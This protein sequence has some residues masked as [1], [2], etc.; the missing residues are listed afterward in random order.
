MHPW[1]TEQ[2]AAYFGAIGGTALGCL[3]GL[4]GTLA[5]IYAPRGRLRRTVLGLMTFSVALG[6]ICLI[7]GVI[8]LI[9]HQPYAVWYPLTLIGVISTAVLGGLLPMVKGRYREAE[10]RRLDAES[11]RRG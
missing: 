9:D 8:A 1:W 2:H 5:G 6:A 4:I 7:A 10:N 11:L 3:G